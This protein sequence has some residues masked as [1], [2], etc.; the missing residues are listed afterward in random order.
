[1]N[2]GLVTTIV[3]LVC[4]LPMHAAFAQ[5][6]VFDVLIRKAKGHAFNGD[7]ALFYLDAAIEVATREDDN[8]KLS[9]AHE[10]L[11]MHW[12][13][14]KEYHQSLAHI[15]TAVA[16]T[17]SAS[18]AE[19]HAL[20]MHV[21]GIYYQQLLE[22]D[23]AFHYYHKAIRQLE[24][25][26]SPYSIWKP[27][28]YLG[29][30]Y[31]IIGDNEKADEYYTKALEI[32]R[33]AGLSQDYGFLLYM[34]GYQYRFMNMDEK[35]AQL[36]E[37]Y[38]RYKR[39]NTDDILADPTH[40]HVPNIYKDPEKR[41]QDIMRFL[42]LHE[43][44]GHVHSLIT[45]YQRLGN[46][47]FKL[48]NNEQAYEYFNIALEKSREAKDKLFQYGLLYNLY[49][50]EKESGDYS[51]ALSRHEELFAL[52]DSI[53][54]AQKVKQ[55]QDLE[56]K[57]ETI[58]K[59]QD[60][61]IKELQLA[62]SRR[63][64]LLTFLGLIALAIA[65]ILALITVRTKQ[66]SNRKLGE[67][68][69]IIS[70]A[71]EEKDIL[72]REI[73]H[74]VKNN[75]QMISALLYLQGKSIDDPTAQDAIKESQNRVQSMAMLHQN[76]YQDEDLLGVEI[77]DYLDKLFEHLFASYDIEKN[78]IALRK[79]IEDVNLDVDTVIPLALIVNELIS[80]SLKHAFRDGR[81][82]QIDVRLTEREDS[83]VLEVS[84]NGMGLPAG[85]DA[86]TSGNFGYKLINILTERMGA[87]WTIQREG[88]TRVILNML[89]Q[90]A[91]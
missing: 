85:F 70:R 59:E 56:V 75:L 11:A 32:T 65:V 8:G 72:L 63:T 20:L 18:H 13:K 37:E 52:R 81:H 60:L 43:K 54:D 76:L 30:V 80:N 38:L 22:Y 61:A 49:K 62:R 39:Q 29:E 23:S 24:S 41:R 16:V 57:Y 4:L 31:R 14:H 64:Q 58:Q 42:E 48:G 45:S 87:E 6:E 46:L 55:L 83:L 27:Y 17:D 2:F 15:D 10:A 77:K 3:M 7:S 86:A 36:Q 79:E 66:R 67:K 34:I 73:H 91:A 50:R 40:I 25:I 5:D 90:K 74:R 1:M 44:H 89:K 71:L 33:P 9:R 35:S 69:A 28:F 47:E 84:D 21:K 19:D 68:N 53:R 12:L 26:G 82:G 51:E 88:G 78:R